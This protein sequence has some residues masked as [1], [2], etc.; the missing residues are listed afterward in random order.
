MS[1]AIDNTL[2]N[3]FFQNIVSNSSLNWEILKISHVIMSQNISEKD[4]IILHKIIIGVGIMDEKEEIK[5][6]LESI[7][8]TDNNL[9]LL[10][11]LIFQ[12][13]EEIFDIDDTDHLNYLLLDHKE[14]METDI[15]YLLR[16]IIVFIWKELENI[17]G[18]KEGI[19]ELLSPDYMSDHELQSIKIELW[20]LFTE[21]WEKIK[22]G[23]EVE[24]LKKEVHNSMSEKNKIFSIK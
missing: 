18:K 24:N 22:Q 8:D 3:I 6:V 13:V 23:P 10:Y 7:R 16:D 5:N 17:F 12:I 20:D 15:I 4:K 21:L 9:F 19:H 14:E 11:K 2:E 1:E